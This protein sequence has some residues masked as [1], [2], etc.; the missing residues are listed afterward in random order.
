MNKI[1]YMLQKLYYQVLRL[2]PPTS[3]RMLNNKWILYFIFVVG[4]VD[5][6]NFYQRGNL[7]AV[8][9]FCIVGFLTSFFSKNMIVIIV[10]AIAV[11]HLVTY[12]NRMSEGMKDG[13][14]EE[15]EDGEEGF[16]EEEE[17]ETETETETEEGSEEEEEKPKEG[18]KEKSKDEKPKDVSTSDLLKKQGELMEKMSQLEPLLNRAEN[19]FKTQ[20]TDGFQNMGKSTPF[21][22]YH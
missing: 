14:E 21:S 1:M 2:I 16:E 10:M 22:E 17:E 5:V 6:V 11:S 12:G 8:A 3:G 15:E 18:M 7:M 19:L 4:M 20:K 13:E 9:V